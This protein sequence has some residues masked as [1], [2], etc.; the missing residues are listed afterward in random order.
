MTHWPSKWFEI[1]AE[2]GQSDLAT[3]MFQPIGGELQKHHFHHREADGFGKI[4]NILLQEGLKLE[5]P[6]RK[7]KK[8]PNYLNFYLLIKGLLTHPRLPN[9][10]WKSYQPELPSADPDQ[11]S[12]W[13]LSANENESIKK[14]AMEKKLNLGFFLL[15]ELD[16]I[17][18]KHLFKNPGDEGS[19]LAPVDLRG[20]FASTDSAKNYVSFVVAKIKQPNVEQSFSNYKN[21]LKSGAYWPFWELAQIGQYVGLAGMRWL[22]KKGTGKSFWMGSFSDLGVWNQPEL[23]S[24]H[25]SNRYW[26]MAPP[27][28]TA[29]PIGITTIEWCGHRSITLKIH[30]SIC[31]GE[32]KKVA[33]QILQEFKQSI[34][35]T[36]AKT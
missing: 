35:K 25:L 23:L 7:L 6:I 8:P 28:S 18:K 14:Q 31:R 11:V 5:A 33:D 26:S 30:P 29:Y 2:M 21:D 1:R 32:S 16:L 15:S 3:M 34:L 12:Y 19:W 20:A 36:V 4:Q 13:F 27:G 9:N 22:A 10:P 24:H 17:L